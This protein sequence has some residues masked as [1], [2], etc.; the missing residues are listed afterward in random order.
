MPAGPSQA[1]PFLRSRWR[2]RAR[3]G[4]LSCER[5]AFA[6]VRTS[7]VGNGRALRISARLFGCCFCCFVVPESEGWRCAGC[8]IARGRRRN[9]ALPNRSEWRS[10]A[11]LSTNGSNVSTRPAVGSRRLGSG[12]E[13][14]RLR[15]LR[16]RGSVPKSLTRSRTKEKNVAR[17]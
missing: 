15:T 11:V 14:S 10:M 2:I 7:G 3:R 1:P 16:R 17:N 9:G 12:L 4:H 8:L 6:L 13:R 5:A